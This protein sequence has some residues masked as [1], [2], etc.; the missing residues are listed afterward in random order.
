[1]LPDS[2]EGPRGKRS[3]DGDGTGE[4]WRHTILLALGALGLA[5]LSLLVGVS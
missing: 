3:F 4:N 1:M 5:L 2:S